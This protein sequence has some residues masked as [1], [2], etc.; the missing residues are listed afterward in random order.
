MSSYGLQHS[1]DR[2][3]HEDA[4]LAA[5]MMQSLIH[6]VLAP[7]DRYLVVDAVVRAFALGSWLLFIFS[8]C[9][10]KTCWI[11][12]SRSSLPWRSLPETRMR[13]TSFTTLP[14]VAASPSTIKALFGSRDELRRGLLRLVDVFIHTR[15]HCSSIIPKSLHHRDDLRQ[16]VPFPICFSASDDV[17]PV[18]ACSGAADVRV[19][20]AV[21]V[22]ALDRRL[23]VVQDVVTFA[24]SV[25][26]VVRLSAELAVSRRA[27]ATVRLRFGPNR[28]HAFPPKLYKCLRRQ[29]F[30]R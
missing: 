7:V 3:H 8:A 26:L 2:V 9:V 14:T 18:I 12:F 27:R 21:E 6:C 1:G 29:V 15:P 28:N 24:A 17:I 30:R 22:T 4:W 23:D 11:A 25:S 10:V 16:I 20:E 19:P 5:P 13:S